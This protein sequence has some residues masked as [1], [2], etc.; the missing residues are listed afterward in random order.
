MGVLFF[1]HCTE[2]ERCFWTGALLVPRSQVT[3]G[4]NLLGL[5]VLQELK[6]CVVTLLR[7]VGGGVGWGGGMHLVADL[8]FLC[9]FP[10]CLVADVHSLHI[11]YAVD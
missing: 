1:R 7:A 10:S 6:M 4:A 8:L 5:L 9:M 11:W 3:L 2:G